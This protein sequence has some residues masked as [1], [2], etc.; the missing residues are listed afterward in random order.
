MPTNKQ[1]LECLE[2]MAGRKCKEEGELHLC[3]LVEK[4]LDYEDWSLFI[5]HLGNV[6]RT[7][8][9]VNW[10]TPYNYVS[11]SWQQRVIALAKVKGIEL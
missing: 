4:S 6:V 10:I 8:Q 11:A 2:K 3:W 5:S 9:I 1:L 7:N